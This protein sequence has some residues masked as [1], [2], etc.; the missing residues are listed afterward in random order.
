MKQLLAI[1]VFLFG[2]SG[3]AQNTG[4]A[5]EVTVCM[6]SPFQAYTDAIDFKSGSDVFL[7]DYTSE[8]EAIAAIMMDMEDTFFEIHGH[9]DNVGSSAGN[10]KLSEQ[11]AEKIRD[12]LI[13]MGCDPLTLKA[14][15]FGESMPVSPNTTPEGR[16]LNRRID[17]VIAGSF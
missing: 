14:V 6:G 17:I 2:F 12:I 10:Q 11:R 7:N 15:G 13:I 3:Y 4:K 5:V 1:T 8:L 9:T 16:A